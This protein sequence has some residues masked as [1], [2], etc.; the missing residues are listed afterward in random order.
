[1]TTIGSKHLEKVCEDCKPLTK[2]EIRE[3]NRITHNQY[4]Q[5]EK[6]M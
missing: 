1:M 5:L 4:R 6:V 3:L 2:K